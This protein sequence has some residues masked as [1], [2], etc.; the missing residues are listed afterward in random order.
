MQERI[1]PER[2]PPLSA[3][4]TFEAAARHLSFTR[5][6]D[7]LHVTQAAV[8]HQIRTL[9]EHLGVMLFRRLNRRLLLTD[10]GQLLMPSVRRAFDELLAGVERV[11]ERCMGGTLTISTTPSIAANWLAG[12]LGRFQALHPEFEIRL[13]A[14][15]RLIDFAREGVDC[16]IR[17]GFGEWPGLRALCL[18]NATLVPLCSPRLLE[19]PRPLR[20]PADLAHHTLLH[21]LDD[22]DDWRLWLQAAG[23]TGVDPT[24][25]L[26]FESL[27][28]AL[29]AA[30]SGAGVVIVA[31]PMAND[32]LDAGR[33]V[34]PFD[35]ELPRECAYYFVAPEASADQPKIRAFRDWL[36]QEV[37]APPSGRTPADMALASD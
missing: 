8:S 23:V 37:D 27:P 35:L 22:M 6:A 29:R 36:L 17:Y 30:V 4:R 33:V 31:G 9:E 16:G 18:L 34:Q 24:R 10:E 15:P 2:L 7:E 19:G 25:G 13:M 32:D 1:M 3:L 21:T 11:R 26:K 12:R 14:T 5:A 28:L 20:T